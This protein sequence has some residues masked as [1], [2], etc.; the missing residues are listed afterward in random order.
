[1]KSISDGIGNLM[2]EPV[3]VDLSSPPREILVT[4]EYKPAPAQ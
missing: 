2:I 1:V 3:K 4:L